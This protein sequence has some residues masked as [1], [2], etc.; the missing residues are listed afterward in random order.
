MKKV[1]KV[2][3]FFCDFCKEEASGFCSSCEKDICAEHTCG[4]LVLK[5][6]GYYFPTGTR[7]SIPGRKVCPD[8]Y[9]KV[10][11][12]LPFLSKKVGGKK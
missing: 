2:K 4:I 7:H 3:K 11:K 12:I 1:V 9:R 6:R 8:C 5:P 10:S